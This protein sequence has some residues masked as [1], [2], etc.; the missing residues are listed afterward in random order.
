[1]LA[2]RQKEENKAVETL[3]KATAAHDVS[4]IKLHDAETDLKVRLTYC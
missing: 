2:K 3:N 1:M 4:A